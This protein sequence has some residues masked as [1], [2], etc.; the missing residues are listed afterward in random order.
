MTTG[1]VYHELYMWHENG[2]F[3]GFMPYGNPVQPFVHSEHQ[4]T[5]RRMRNLLDVSG[6][7]KDLVHI[8]PREAQKQE[9][10][11]FHT[12]EYYEKIKAQN[13]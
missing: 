10:C 6:L 12:P 5:K 9:I 4:E 11:R 13:D 7:L 8:E 2:N 3:A 1:F